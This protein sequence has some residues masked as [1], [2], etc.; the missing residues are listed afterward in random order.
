M[1][2]EELK[3]SE[4]N[5]SNL[6]CLL[7][8]GHALGTGS[9]KQKWCD[10]GEFSSQA[11][12]GCLLGMKRTSF[13]SASTTWSRY[14]TQAL[15]THA[16]SLLTGPALEEPKPVSKQLRNLF[17]SPH[18]DMSPRSSGSRGQMYEISAEV[19][20]KITMLC[21]WIAVMCR[22]STQRKMGL[23]SPPAP[24]KCTRG[25]LQGAMREMWVVTHDSS[26]VFM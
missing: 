25:S 3:R 17:H 24:W 12:G 8:A 15:G 14:G 5:S 18:S 10:R 7:L 21:A 26:T 22:R 1:P 13:S 9:E 16:V 19:L 2:Q 11:T 4:L 6:E 20:M 23:P